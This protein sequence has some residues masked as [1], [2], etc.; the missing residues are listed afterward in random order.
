MSFDPDC[1]NCYNEIVGGQVFLCHRHRNMKLIFAN[2]IALTP[3]LLQAALH[4]CTPEQAVAP[5]A[6]VDAWESQAVTAMCDPKLFAAVPRVKV[7]LAGIPLEIDKDMPIDRVEFRDKS[8]A[9]LARIVGL[10]F[11][12]L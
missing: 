6:Q 8:G 12:N 11:P 4:G 3:A 7:T 9:V 1:P 5:R 2:G 10:G